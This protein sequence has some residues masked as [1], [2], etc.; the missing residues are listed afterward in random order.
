MHVEPK[1]SSREVRELLD[2]CWQAGS[3]TH[4][5]ASLQVNPE[6]SRVKATPRAKSWVLPCE[7]DKKKKSI[8][9]CSAQ[10]NFILEVLVLVFNVTRI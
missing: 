2:S 6:H 9:W 5:A 1:Y 10:G 7:K 4:L 8:Y 3:G